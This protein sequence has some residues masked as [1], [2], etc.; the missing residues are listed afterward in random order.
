MLTK[1]L[2]ILEKYYPAESPHL[3]RVKTKFDNMKE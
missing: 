2:E 1:A 3:A